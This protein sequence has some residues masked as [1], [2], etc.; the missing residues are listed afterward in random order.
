MTTLATQEIKV[1][2][3]TVH[4]DLYIHSPIRLHDAVLNKLSAGTTL[5]FTFHYS[6]CIA[7]W[8][9]RLRSKHVACSV[10][11]RCMYRC[12]QRSCHED[13]SGSRHTL[14]LGT[15][16]RAEIRFTSRPLYLQTKQPPPPPVKQ[17]MGG[18]GGPTADLD[19]KNI[20][21]LPGIELQFLGRLGI[22][23]IWKFTC[24]CFQV[25]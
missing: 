13:T 21:F 9:Q 16:W 12:R 3:I 22:I 5:P 25:L 10:I 15:R 23:T 1:N 24:D 4:V 20:S 2:F 11:R 7:A 6:A 18:W 8:W 19:A 14:T 17:R